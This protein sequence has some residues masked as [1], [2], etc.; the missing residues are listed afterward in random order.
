VSVSERIRKCWHDDHNDKFA[1]FAVTLNIQIHGFL[2]SS[3][4]WNLISVSLFLFCLCLTVCP[5]L[6]VRPTTPAGLSEKA[7][8]RTQSWV[9]CAKAIT[10]VTI[11]SFF[12]RKFS[13]KSKVLGGC[14]WTT[15]KMKVFFDYVLINRAH[16][17]GKYFPGEWAMCCSCKKSVCVFVCVCVCVC[18]TVC[19]LQTI[20]WC[21]S[22]YLHMSVRGR[23]SLFA[24][25][26]EDGGVI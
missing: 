14:M 25:S 16:S 22:Q 24:C 10:Q 23:F 12:C 8:A 6:F 3:Y 13:C 2:F 17:P 5:L 21:G 26:S 1:I 7:L 15:L 9:C 4:R 20:I 18:A 11:T 19:S